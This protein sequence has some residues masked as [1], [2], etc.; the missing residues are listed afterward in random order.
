[1][2]LGYADPPYIGQAKKHYG[3]QPSFAGEVDHAQLLE[4]LNRE[5]PDGWALSCKSDA[6]ELAWL[7]QQAEKAGGKV[8]L[9]VWVKPFASFKPNVNPGYCFEPVLFMGGR[10]RGRG[11]PT[12]RDFVSANITLGR[13][14]PGAKPD[15][16]S[17]WV[18]EFLGMEPGD[19]L[20]D[21]FPGTGAVGNLWVELGTP[22]CG[23][24]ACSQ[25]RHHGPCTILESD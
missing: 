19:Q 17:R 2:R 20:V 5:F 18:F 16:F 11:K 10:K 7:I 8:R 25:P 1:M 4:R 14:L 12:L 6:T 15:D 3:D 21:L 13:G 23:D 22:L 9:G 24:G